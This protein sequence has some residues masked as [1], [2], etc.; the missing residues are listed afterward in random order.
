VLPLV[1]RQVAHEFVEHGQSTTTDLIKSAPHII[2]MWR[3]EA[4]AQVSRE[5][6]E[7]GWKEDRKD[8]SRADF[9]REPSSSTGTYQ[10]LRN[11]RLGSWNPIFRLEFDAGIDLGFVTGVLACFEFAAVDVLYQLQGRR[12]SGAAG[13]T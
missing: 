2:P 5:E 6:I 3:Q 11:H 13:I 8:L 7:T 10:P 1:D 12:G 4:V 9:D